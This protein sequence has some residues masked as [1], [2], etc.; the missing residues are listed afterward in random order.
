MQPNFEPH[1]QPNQPTPPG[2]PAPI[3][4]PLNQAHSMPVGNQYTVDPNNLPKNAGNN[5]FQ[6]SNPGGQPT[7]QDYNFILNPTPPVRSSRGVNLPN[8][9]LG[10]IGLILGGLIVL[11]ILIAII[12][13][14]L[15]S[16]T[17][18][19]Y[20]LSVLQDQQELIHI[21]TEAASASDITGSNQNFVSTA[22]LSI[23]SSSTQLQ[24]YLSARGYKPSAKS[25]ALKKSKAVDNELTNAENIGN[26]NSTFVSISKSQL[27]TY[28]GDL[29]LAY[30]K[31]SGKHIR[32]LLSS[33][34]SQAKLLQTSISSGS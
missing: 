4:N 13:S 6:S 17:N 12:S 16:P 24:A 21:S 33:F 15:K 26:F 32:S 29:R 34:Y 3:P 11:V 23:S 2:A 5:L 10:R 31:S 20:Y 22:G 18:N 25:L 27:N 7:G 30:S 28:L 9:M 1:S 19:S 8:G 14:L